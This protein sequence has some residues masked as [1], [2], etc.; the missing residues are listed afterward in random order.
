MSSLRISV[1]YGFG[2]ILQYFAF[3]DFKK[4]QKLLLQPLKEMYIV[5]AVFA[6]CLTCF[7]GS[8]VSDCFGCPPP[9]MENYLQIKTTV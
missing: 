2:K 6:N 1:E 3:L 9:T 7:H 8:Q 4:N 5:A